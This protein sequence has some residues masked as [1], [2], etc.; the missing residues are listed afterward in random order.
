MDD[1]QFSPDGGRSKIIEKDRDRETKFQQSDRPALKTERATHTNHNQA[2]YLS[3]G[4][5]V[6]L[7]ETKNV[8]IGYRLSVLIYLTWLDD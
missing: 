5:S 2:K 6:V 7:C 1:W 8:F 3:F 4:C